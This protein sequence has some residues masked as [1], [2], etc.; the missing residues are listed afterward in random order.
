MEVSVVVSAY[1]ISKMGCLMDC[2]E[3]LHRQSRCPDE[4]ILIL[5]PCPDL[6]ELCE[7]K[8][9]KDVKI[10]VSEKR[11]LANARNLGVRCAKGDIVTF[12][13]D[14][15]IADRDWLRNHMKNYDDPNVVGVGGYARPIWENGRP[16]WFPEELD[17]TVGCSYKGL[18]E[19]KT[20]VRNPIGCNMSFRRSVFQKVGYFRSD[21]GRFGKL[22]LAGE[23]A[24]LSI[25]ILRMMSGCKIMY[26]PSALIY[27][28]VGENRGKFGYL[29]KRSFY[30]GVSKALIA[31]RERNPTACLTVENYYLKYLLS[32]A[33]PSKLKRIRSAGLC[34]LVVLFFSTSAVFAGFSSTRL[35]RRANGV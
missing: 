16:E 8:L 5:Y 7:S 28:R 27:H 14:D 33:V 10:V 19:H 1:S 4:I 20:D 21:V 30:E 9:P 29:L 11:G 17:W 15:A 26:E 2:I 25:R 24:E 18:P 13:D 32:V 3:S 6:V 22:L 35:R 23:E 12:I 31:S 34:Q